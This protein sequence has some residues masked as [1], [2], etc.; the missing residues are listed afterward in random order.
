MV[1]GHSGWLEKPWVA[2]WAFFVVLENAGIDHWLFILLLYSDF[3]V[4]AFFTCSIKIPLFD[5]STRPLPYV[6]LACI[7]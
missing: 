2:H 4:I 5:M 1:T 6:H 3:H 7:A